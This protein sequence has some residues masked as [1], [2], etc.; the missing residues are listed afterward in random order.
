MSVVA[1]CPFCVC[2]HL[3]VFI[4][5]GRLLDAPIIRRYSVCQDKNKGKLNLT[6]RDE[7]RSKLE[8]MATLENRSLS[9][10]VEVMAEERWKRLA[11]EQGVG[12]APRL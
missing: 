5:G 11:M 6:V 10:L 3:C 12:D 4:V 2:F 1:F 9:N 8:K 7:Q